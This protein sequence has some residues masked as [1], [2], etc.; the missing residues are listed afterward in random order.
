MMN[1]KS[2]RS[3]QPQPAVVAQHDLFLAATQ[4]HVDMFKRYACKQQHELMTQDGMGCTPLVIAAKHGHAAVVTTILSSSFQ[5]AKEKHELLELADMYGRTALHH[6]TVRTHMDCMRYLMENGASVDAADSR[7][8]CPL[9]LCSAV[10]PARLLIEHGADALCRNNVQDTPLQHMKRVGV[11]SEQLM[12]FLGQ[13]ERT[14]QRRAVSKTENLLG[15]IPWR[16]MIAAFFI[17]LLLAIYLVTFKN[18]RRKAHATS[19][20]HRF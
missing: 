5:S 6:A 17:A 7:G 8:C 15:E 3:N 2:R 4:G 16:T 19:I 18:E 14:L 13:Q 9:H 1:R 11:S 12:L 10:A 20:I